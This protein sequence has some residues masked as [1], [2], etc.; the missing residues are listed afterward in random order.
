MT[1]TSYRNQELHDALRAYTSRALEKLNAYGKAATEYRMEEPR[2]VAR[3]DNMFEQVQ[4]APV[5][6]G[7][8]IAFSEAVL[9]GLPEYQEVHEVLQR[10]PVVAP[11]M[12]TLV[13]TSL[14]MM[15]LDA[16]QIVNAIA[17]EIVRQGHALEY[18]TD[19][20]ESE[21]TR[22]EEF[23]WSDDI[24]HEWLNVLYG[25]TTLN[26]VELDD[27]LT[28][29]R[30]SDAQICDLLNMGIPMG[31]RMSH[32]ATS[33]ARFAIRAR[34]KL[35]KVVGEARDEDNRRNAAEVIERNERREEHVIRI[36]RLFKTGPVYSVASIRTRNSLFPSGYSF[37]K[38]KEPRLSCYN[39]YELSKEDMPQL[40][41]LWNQSNNLDKQKKRHFLT[42]ALRRF[43]QARD[44]TDAE[45]AMI[46]LLICAEALFLTGIGKDRGELG[47]RL[48]QR[49]AFFVE[50]E[51][52]KRIRAFKFIKR[53]YGVR[54]EI[55][56]GTDT[57]P[58]LPVKKDGTR[59][60]LEECCAKTE[61]Y[62]RRALKKAIGIA[63]DPAA[64]KFL[65]DWE[66]LIFRLEGEGTSEVQ[67]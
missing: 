57:P 59:Y 51:P 50:D 32:V 3:K 67:S 11:Q 2:W 49:A 37:S 65:I 56:H 52:P 29:V 36:L 12:D 62:L 17:F 15:R 60:T 47:Y 9:Q 39:K 48:S 28:I 13:G 30:L 16:Y 44:R 22:L 46:D 20:F 1:N 8:A 66:S 7:F 33:V 6:W 53:M 18:N 27:T 4:N 40:R 55:V 58:K 19:I 64:P 63:Q 41:Q 26:D 23:L 35:P 38:N 25:F 34:E 5:R 21:Y 10:D 31:H 14:E 61:E 45:D 24:E 42:V 54:S 43:S